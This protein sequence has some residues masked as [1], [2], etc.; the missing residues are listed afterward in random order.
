MSNSKTGWPDLCPLDRGG[1]MSLMCVIYDA[2]YCGLG[3][4]VREY[5]AR[6]INIST[7]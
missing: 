3:G 1:S 4:V 5:S 7:S 6:Y 2:E